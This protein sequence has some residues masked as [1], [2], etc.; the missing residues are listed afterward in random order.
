MRGCRNRAIICRFVIQW[1]YSLLFTII[2]GGLTYFTAAAKQRIETR[3]ISIGKAEG[4]SN[5]IIYSI[6]QDYKG[7]IWLGTQGG[8]NRFDGYKMLVFRHDPLDSTTIASNNAGN[9]YL[10]RTGYIWIGTWGD[11]LDRFDPITCRSIHF[12]HDE[13]SDKGLCSNCVQT[14]HQDFRG[15]L[16]IG[17]ING[18]N[19][20]DT[21]SH[22]LCSFYFGNPKADIPGLNR[23]WSICDTR[24]SLLWIGTDL[25]L[26]LFNPIT[27]QRKLFQ[28]MPQ[29]PEYLE[30][31]RI[32]KIFID[33]HG[34]V[35]I[36]SQQGLFTFNEKTGLFCPTIFNDFFS[37]N[38]NDKSINTII[39]TDSFLWV[40]TKRNGLYRYHPQSGEL[41]SFIHSS[42]DPYSIPEN[43]IRTLLLDATDVLWI[44]MHDGGICKT[45]LKKP[46]FQSLQFDLHFSLTLNDQGVWSIFEDSHANLW[47]GTR[48]GGI[49]FWNRALDTIVYYKNESKNPNSLSDN[50]ILS[51]FEDRTGT[52]WV[53]TDR[54]FNRY[55]ASTDNFTRF[56]HDPND[57]TTISGNSIYDICDDSAGYLWLATYRT[58]LNRFNTQTGQSLRFYANESDS[59]SL[60][61]NT[62]Y[63]LLRD[64]DDY[65]WVGTEN[66]LNR[67][68]PQTL[69]FENQVFSDHRTYLFKNEK[70]TCLCRA[71]NQCL[72]IGTANGLFQ[73]ERNF[74]QFT[75]FIIKDGLPGLFIKGILEDS[76]ENLWITTDNGLWFLNPKS[77]LSFNY[78]ASD[79]LLSLE[80]C[81]NAAIRSRSGELFFGNLNGLN[82]IHPN[83]IP[84]YEFSSP[85]ILTSFRIFSHEYLTD[86]LIS[87]IKE[88]SLDWRENSFSFEFVTLDY[89]L[90]ERNSYRYRL[91]GFE[92]EWS[93]RSSRRFA[94]YTNVA[95]GNY[96][97]Q[98][99]SVNSSGQW[100]K[101]VNLLTIHI[102]PPFWKELWFRVLMFLLIFLIFFSVY[103]L[104]IRSLRNK[105]EKL[106]IIVEERTQELQIANE[107]LEKMARTDPLTGLSN[108][109]DIL[110]KIE[111][112]LMQFKRYG[113]RFTILICDLDNFKCIN[114]TYG[115]D[116]GDY[117]LVEA[118]KI[119]KSRLREQ[120]IVSRW[121]GEEFLILLSDT[122]LYGGQITAER[123]RIALD[124]YIFYY[125]KQEIHLTMTMGL[126]EFVHQI[127][128][129]EC[130]KKA[131]EALYK[132]KVSG[133]NQICLADTPNKVT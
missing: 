132:G 49:N 111:Y 63:C 48:Y 79:G 43:D 30:A 109:R 51:F 95:P 18:L 8:L 97:F 73:M 83:Q 58:G 116:C 91:A 29:S 9:L 40:G 71:A 41:T 11:G 13:Q 125:C 126:C 129:S 106:R 37:V 78:S 55:N 72:W 20:L 32:R 102:H 46:K 39:E 103:I 93:E 117:I 80:F 35:W 7:F 19:R 61:N 67:M 65:I 17:T 21:L 107:K 100:D 56:Y 57:S 105:A 96:I 64:A 131:D 1:L 26:I 119:I 87:Y 114:D 98:V 89:A 108:R 15:N 2:W 42:S 88:V 14:I 82:W 68:N 127:T 6:I 112:Q 104:R 115:H 10:D 74:N 90:A 45:D 133:K 36:G 94:N 31:N 50:D 85:T 33:C 3:F 101:P 38:P 110:E 62:V 123:I 22:K 60:S 120:D 128:I 75:K 23:I 47:L 121:G 16:W 76:L 70:I 84:D 118:V 92:N 122:D 124:T 54:G 44:G 66:G 27:G 34:T 77:G 81:Q 99:K 113:H 86:S 53:G 24:D 130:I 4:L 5:S 25:G 69:Q 52:L 28:P 12:T 59:N